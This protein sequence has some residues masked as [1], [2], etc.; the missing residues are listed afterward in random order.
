MTADVVATWA[1]VGGICV[2]RT[3]LVSYL[4]VIGGFMLVRLLQHVNKTTVT[5]GKLKLL[6]ILD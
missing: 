3:R 4:Q 6:Y 5:N 1:M 2:L